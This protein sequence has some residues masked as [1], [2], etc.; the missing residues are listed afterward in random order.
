MHIVS[1]RDAF[2][3]DYETLHFFL[4]LQRQHKWN[5]PH[6]KHSH[7]KHSYYHP[8][9]QSITNDTIKYLCQYS[10]T[11]EQGEQEELE[12]E[13]MKSGSQSDKNPLL[14]RMDDEKFAQLLHK[15]NN[16][17]LYKAEKL[18]IVNQLPNNMVHLYSIVEE[19]DTRFNESQVTEILEI[20]AAS[21]CL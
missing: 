8:E 1:E 13:R 10:E 9:L 12:E 20:V 15:L 17:T 19:C 18:Q 5:K 6:D 7:N 11:V 14:L 2:M 3:S 16:F 4:D 21:T